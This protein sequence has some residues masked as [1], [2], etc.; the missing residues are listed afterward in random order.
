MLVTGAEGMLG[1]DVVRA[2]RLMNH[3]V[4][5]VTHEELDIRDA[6]AV[7]AAFVERYPH[8]VVNCA[9]W[10]DV[11]G[12]EDDPEGAMAVNRDGARNV[13]AAAAALR[14]PVVLPSTDYVFDGSH[15]EPY[16]ESDEADPQS[17]Y[18]RSKLAGEIA[19]A[20]ENPAHFV[21]RT[22]WLFG[23]GGHNFVETMLSLATE[24]G[25]VLVVMDQVGCPTYTGHLAEAILRLL[26]G[27]MYGTHHI[28]AAGEC[29]W[30]EF[31][32]EIFRAAKLDCRVMAATTDMVPRKAKR[33]A[34]SVLGTEREHP[35]LLPDWHE[36]L[37]TYLADRAR[38]AA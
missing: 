17:E 21:V 10:T 16:I 13:A 20:Q 37:T 4:L 38:T 15:G 3:E 23:V 6:K 32:I 30:Y 2:T 24:L 36:G 11:D 28:A 12:A 35:I 9:A 18:G 8:A 27:D 1:S 33:P 26:D 19:T 7:E 25:E 22:S 34:Y 5:P 31:A 29:S 14:V